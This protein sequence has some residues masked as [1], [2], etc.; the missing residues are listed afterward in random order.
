[1]ELAWRQAQGERGGK[2]K[3]KRRKKSRS[4]REGDDLLT[5]TLRL[6]SDD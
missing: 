5:R 1:M 4:W 2:R 3:G 6:R